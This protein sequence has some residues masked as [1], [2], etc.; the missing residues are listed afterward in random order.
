MGWL[1]HALNAGNG[2]STR[3]NLGGS[4]VYTPPVLTQK[5]KSL[6]ERANVNDTFDAL[7]RGGASLFGTLGQA[8][9]RIYEAPISLV[10]TAVQRS[11]G[12]SPVQALRNTPAG[13]VG[14]ALGEAV[15][16][17]GNFIPAIINSKDAR[18]WA[19]VFDL[20]DTTEITDQLVEDQLGLP[21]H[22]RG[23]DWSERT[24]GVPLLGALFGL[25][26]RAKTVGEFREELAK[27]GFFANPET[28]EAI[29]PTE[30]GRMIRSGGRGS[31]DFG[32]SAIND[33]AL[34]D[35]AGRVALDPSNVLF[36]VP[37]ANVAKAASLGARWLPKIATA[38]RLA[39]AGVIAG[40]AAPVAARSA[41]AIMQGNRAAATL[42]GLGRVMRGY[43][44]L[45]IGTAAGE[46]AVNRISAAVNDATGDS[47][48]F[49][50]EIEEFTNAVEQNQPL[51]G[52]A[53][54]M[55]LS[56]AT[57]PYG[58]T[59]VRPTQRAA[60][61]VRMATVGLDDLAAIRREFGG[62]EAMHTALGGP[63]GTQALADFL[64]VQI[65]REKYG[66]SPEVTQ[67]A[68]LTDLAL[69]RRL[70]QTALGRIVDRMRNRGEIT[71]DMRLAKF[72]EWHGQQAGFADKGVTNPW[73]A[74]RAG[75]RW[76]E[77]MQVRS[78]IKPLL[79]ET[80]EA[81]WGL[82]DDVIFTEQLDAGR[83]SLQAA[84]YKGTD[85]KFRIPKQA[86]LDFLED[87]PNV[88]A[89]DK[90]GTWTKW[91]DE[92]ASDPTWEAVRAK[93]AGQKRGSIKSSDYFAEA[94]LW[95]ESAPRDPGVPEGPVGD[96]RPEVVAARATDALR[97]RIPGGE[98]AVAAADA[99]AAADDL[100]T[101][102]FV[103]PGLRG[104]DP[105]TLRRVIELE[106]EVAA[107]NPSYRIK[108]IGPKQVLADI[109]ADG[110]IATALRQRTA[111]GE[112]AME[113]SPFSTFGKFMH[114]LTRPVT[115]SELKN[116]ARQ[117]LMND[118]IPRGL[119]PSQVNAVL[120]ALE[121]RVSE[122]VFIDKGS[123]K[124]QLFR[125]IGSLLPGQVNR[126]A[127]RVLV[128]EAPNPGAAK[129]AAKVLDALDRDGGMYRALSRTGSRYWRS[130]HSK[131][132]KGDK[133][134]RALEN[135]YNVWTEA[136]V[137]KDV[138]TSQRVVAKFIYPVMRFLVD[139]RWLGLNLAEGGILSF[140]KDG[141]IKAYSKADD[142][143]RAGRFFNAN[144]D[145]EVLA[146][147]AP[148]IGS[149]L[150]NKNLQLIAL[151]SFDVRSGKGIGKILDELGESDPA[152][153]AARRSMLREADDLAAAA[154][155]TDD[156]AEAARLTDQAKRLRESGKGPL[157]EW[158]N[159][160]LYRFE[161]DG[162]QKATISEF[163]R[164]LSA[165]EMA[166]MQPL[167][168][169]VVDLNQQTWTDVQHMFH[170]NPSRSTLERVMN[171]GWLYWPLSYQVKAT[172]WL[173]DIMLNG[174]FGH[175]NGALLAGRYAVWQQEHK[176]RLLKN[177]AYAAMYA[178]NPELWFAAQ[179][180]L[181]MGPEDIGVSLSRTGRIIG[182]GAQGFMNEWFKTDIGLFTLQMEPDRIPTWL[183]ELGPMYTAELMQRIAQEADKEGFF[184]PDVP[185]S[186]SPLGAG[187]AS[188]GGY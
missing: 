129:A 56:A 114:A 37:G 23:F 131:A 17:S 156:A 78:V 6:L 12:F 159:D 150:T 147:F 53:A 68:S 163:E 90:Y 21:E 186:T 75:R 104:S 152:I 61:A 97:E 134:A 14:G 74:S 77:W 1:S 140:A 115:R 82:R 153:V 105:A 91:V 65:A 47:I 71:S 29:D 70:E 85:G 171:S 24:G 182:A 99:L 93:I 121:Q 2:S 4:R 142:A 157:S 66:T 144:M 41:E 141:F 98:D 123:F 167:I 162:P 54:F 44:T 86:I 100:A 119:K 178:S 32:S 169:R 176:D 125:D 59:I 113:H 124:A 166:A 127:R 102:A 84:G 3:L 60:R 25:G 139:P 179:M 170:G 34:V 26:T 96:T 110:A 165:D 151:K 103:F 58:Q 175:D 35:L 88:N 130:I 8:P 108:S 92:A 42:A 137:L 106:Q 154:K 15:E 128:D 57:F 117:A 164:L 188:Q 50:R 161:Q 67:Y 184:A 62:T 132:A 19:S 185:P 69:R 149:T 138:A 146:S 111:L 9:S 49:F 76:R 120:R 135:V 160:K 20:P 33:N 73:D 155:A 133:G 11:T 64:D 116:G 52:N 183:I 173:A 143:S 89:L 31:D 13:A 122:S 118:L 172:K 81:I 63:E 48:P 36:L 148:D 39:E 101:P 107:I 180:I 94:K 22:L 27:R 18:I 136:P 55:L 95:E 28:G 45:A 16:R 177:P 168:E 30:L 83:T 79:D 174:S 40:R 158:L 5:P 43:R 10:D 109:P 80:G 38:S 72:Q 112:W 51:S 187:P 46:F 145:P 126:I 87:N 7:S 181:P